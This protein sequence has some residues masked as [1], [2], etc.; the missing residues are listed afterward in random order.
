MGLA[1]GGLM[2]QSISEDV[3]GMDA[4]DTSHSSRC[5]VH[6]LNSAQWT[7]ATG[8]PTPYAPPTAAHYTNAGLPWFEHYNETALDGAAK[9]RG[10]DSVAAKG[11]K[12]G[13]KPLPE[14]EP[15]VPKKVVVSGKGV[16]AE[17]KW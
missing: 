8:L 7:A 17:G 2:R 14:N 16:V 3:Y 1:P 10:L 6:L 4:W 5:F 13:Q 12:L 11:V 9:L 15:V